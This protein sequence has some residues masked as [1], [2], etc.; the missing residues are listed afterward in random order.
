MEGSPDADKAGEYVIDLTECYGKFDEEQQQI[1]YYQLKHTT[2]KEDTPFVLSDLKTTFEGFAKRY[3]QHAA[4]DEVKS[5]DISFTV[6]TN[7]KIEDNFKKGIASIANG[8]TANTT[9]KNTVVKYT[10]LDSIQLKEFCSIINF[11]D[12]E[13]NYNVQKNQLKVEMS[14]LISGTFDNA[15]V[16]SIITLMQEKVLP[17]STGLVVKVEKTV[18]L[19]T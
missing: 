19:T 5:K 9:F 8:K 15:Y 12:G 14:Q 1:K 17:D 6:V 7:R 4:K 3:I 13:G 2:V 18:K 11:E 10:E 16:D